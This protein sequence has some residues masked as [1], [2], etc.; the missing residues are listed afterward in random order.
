MVKPIKETNKTNGIKVPLF[1][2][3]KSR[4]HGQR[5]L[6]SKVYSKEKRDVTKEQEQMNVPRMLRDFS[7]AER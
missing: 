1:V 7:R 2:S 5:I 4:C 6:K 3:A